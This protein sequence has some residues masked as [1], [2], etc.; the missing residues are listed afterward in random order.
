MILW[1]KRHSWLLYPKFQRIVDVPINGEDRS[2]IGL[3]RVLITGRSLN[4]WK[5]VFLWLFVSNISLAISN[6]APGQG[7]DGLLAL[8]SYA[9][10]VYGDALTQD[11]LV[12]MVENAAVAYVLVN[13][14]FSLLSMLAF[15]L[16]FVAAFLMPTR[17]QVLEERYFNGFEPFDD[18]EHEDDF[19]Q[20][21]GTDE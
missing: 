13:A 7:L 21:D 19:R 12:S 3:K 2:T 8:R 11:V 4:F 15:L 10:M 17:I 14:V 9:E 16:M 6:T 5:V 18:E 20:D 1:F